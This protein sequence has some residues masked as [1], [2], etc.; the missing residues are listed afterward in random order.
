MY[1]TEDILKEY[2]QLNRRMYEIEDKLNSEK[3]LFHFSKSVLNQTIVEYVTSHLYSADMYSQLYFFTKGLHR[4]DIGKVI[5]DDSPV[6]DNTA[7]FVVEDQ[8][9]VYHYL[10]FEVDE[11]R[12]IKKIYARDSE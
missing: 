2:V 6:S 1:L 3:T 9:Q 7:A 4:L 8:D 10:Y 5:P 11:D 12:V